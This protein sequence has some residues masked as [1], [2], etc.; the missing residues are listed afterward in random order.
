MMLFD[1]Q[2]FI[3]MGDIGEEFD[4]L[5][6]SGAAAVFDLAL[7]NRGYPRDASYW[8]DGSLV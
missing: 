8:A 5:M 6:A 1:T 2:A 7:S 3:G 4:A